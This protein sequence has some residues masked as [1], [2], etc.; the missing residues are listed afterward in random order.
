[1]SVQEIIPKIIKFMKFYGQKATIDVIHSYTGFG[2]ATIRTALDIMH[3]NGL[4]KKENKRPTL[5]QLSENSK[6]WPGWNKFDQ[7]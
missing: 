1:M 3:K 6:Y 4:I 2:K 7:R 5:F